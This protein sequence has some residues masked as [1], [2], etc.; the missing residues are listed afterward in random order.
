[1]FDL[2]NTKEFGEIL[3]TYFEGDTKTSEYWVLLS[4]NFRFLNSRAK[5]V[6]TSMR[7]R[8]ASVG[9]DLDEQEDDLTM[10]GWI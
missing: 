3:P 5:L 9:K 10:I 1:M 2:D 8:V 4:S 6:L 7:K